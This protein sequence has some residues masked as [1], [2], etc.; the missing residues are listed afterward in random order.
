M[1]QVS[2]K[3]K[4]L[5]IIVILLSCI[6]PALIFHNVSAELTILLLTRNTYNDA[7]EGVHP[8][9]TAISVKDDGFFLLVT[10]STRIISIV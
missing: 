2:M 7:F 8:K 6:F 5:A 3:S 1:N 10:H 9:Q 4:N